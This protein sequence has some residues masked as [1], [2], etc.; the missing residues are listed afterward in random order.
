MVS[1][2]DTM[3]NE[4]NTTVEKENELWGEIYSLAHA[5]AGRYLIKHDVNFDGTSGKWAFTITTELVEKQQYMSKKKMMEAI[6][7][8]MGRLHEQDI[9]FLAEETNKQH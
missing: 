8:L 5:K 7:N 2:G 1:N 4:E 9:V 6:Y 3:K